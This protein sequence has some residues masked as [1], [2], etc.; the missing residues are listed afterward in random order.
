MLNWQKSSTNF[1]LGLI[2]VILMM[3]VRIKI[4]EGIVCKS[5]GRIKERK[6]PG[7]YGIG[8]KLLK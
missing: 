2:S 8:G 7:P 1:T 4:D 3:S 6:S 5:F